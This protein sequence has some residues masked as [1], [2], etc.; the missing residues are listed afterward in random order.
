L[1]SPATDALRLINIKAAV[2]NGLCFARQEPVV[3]GDLALWAMEQL[4]DLNDAV[5]DWL[6]E[7]ALV[8]EH[9]F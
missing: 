7:Q 3:A 1:A 9:A 2:V 4:S 8:A 5:F 6:H